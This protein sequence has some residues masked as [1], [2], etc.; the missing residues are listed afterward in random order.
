MILI[1]AA[2]QNKKSLQIAG[3]RGKDTPIKEKAQQR[4]IL[5]GRP[6]TFATAVLNFCVRDGNRCDHRAI[7]ARLFLERGSM[8]FENR[9]FGSTCSKQLQVYFALT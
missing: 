2:F 3:K 5:A 1:E 6:T 9:I 4:A 8:I 7:A